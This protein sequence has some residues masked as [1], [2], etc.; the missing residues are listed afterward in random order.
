[1]W[2]RIIGALI[3]LI[4]LSFALQW[5]FP[6]RPCAAQPGCTP[7]LL[8]DIG[9]ILAFFGIIKLVLSLVEA[10]RLGF[11]VAWVWGS[12]FWRPAQHRAVA[13]DGT[14]VDYISIG[15]PPR[16]AVASRVAPESN[17]RTDYSGL[18]IVLNLLTAGSAPSSKF[19]RRACSACSRSYMT[20]LLLLG[21]L[22]R[23]PP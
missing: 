5:A 6:R 3:I 8:W 21:R 1:M 18:V 23:V 11:L 7:V 2:T 22:A 16:A 19:L 9:P 15:D 20:L 14:L 10:D 12:A 4:V 13:L 17:G